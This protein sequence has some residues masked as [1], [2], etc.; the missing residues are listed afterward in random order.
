MDHQF[1]APGKVEEVM[2]N[3]RDGIQFVHDQTIRYMNK[4]LT[5]DELA[6]EDETAAGSG[7]LRA[8]SAAV[9]RNGVTFGTRNLCGIPGV[10]RRR[11]GGARSDAA[12]ESA[13]RHVSMMG[14][15]DRVLNEARQSMDAGDAQW[16]AELTTYLIRIDHEDRD[17]RAVKAAAF[18]KLGLG[19]EEYQLAQLVSGVGA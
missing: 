17:A 11:S 8:I 18:R 6:A 13:R 5:P 16:A 14:G 10:V 7:S 15:R 3:Y 19:F 12:V 9:L 2:R 1:W 4:G